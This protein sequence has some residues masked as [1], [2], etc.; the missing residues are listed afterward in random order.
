MSARPFNVRFAGLL[1]VLL[2]STALA[3]PLYWDWPEGV[4]LTEV[5]L[6]GAAL[7]EAGHLIAGLGAGP[8]QPGGP[9]VFW[10]IE[11]DGRGGFYSGTGHGGEIHHTDA[12]G[13]ARLVAQ[14]EAAEVFSLLLL[15]G[16]DLLAGC[17]PEGE[18]LRIAPD[19]TVSELA[20]VP[21][22]YVW[23]MSAGPDG[24]IWLATGSPAALWVLDKGGKAAPAVELP[25]QNVLDLAW[26]GA[27]RLL[28]STQGPGL[29]YRLD[30]A[31]PDQPELLFAADQGEVRQFLRGPG[32][33][34][35]VLALEV[36]D[37]DE[38]NG[39]RARP[40][41]GNGGGNG[42]GGGNG[43][44]GMISLRDLQ[45]EVGPPRA[46]L[47][48]LGADGLV[49]PYWSGET[50][51]MIAAW[52]E[53]WGWVGGGVVG[54]DDG[55]STLHRL[56]PPAGMQSLA[57]WE[58]GDVMAILPDPARQRLIVCEAHPGG[59]TELSEQPEGP[60]VAVSRIV[61]AGRSVRWG[62]LRWQ[63]QGAGTAP[64]WSVRS[65]NRAEPDAD[66]SDWSDAWRGHDEPIPAPAGRY[67]Q[68]RVAFPKGEDARSWQVTGVSLS[69][70]RENLPPVIAAFDLE[71]VQEI[72]GGGLM[73]RGDNVTQTLQSGL[74]VEYGRQSS[75]DQRAD[76]A[77][78]AETRSVRTLSWR[79]DDPDGDRLAYDL[80]FRRVGETVWRPV[81]TATQETI[82]A[83]DTAGLAD[84]QYELRLG[85][86]DALDNPAAEALLTRRLLAP[87]A[88]DNTPPVVSRLALERTTRGVRVRFRAEDTAGVLATATVVLP[89]GS[90]ER[91]DP[92]DRI[93]DSAREDFD[94][95]V[96]WPREGAAAAAGPWSL[97]VEVS[98]LGGNRGFADAEVP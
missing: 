2:A 14:V 88:V 31:H 18:L 26:D 5:T 41:G 24:R 32:G 1:P 86:S 19:G 75:R 28:A 16:G 45:L 52:T 62:R 81:L 27:G 29:V 34:L 54:D 8:L 84:G 15:P 42:S 69:A 63:G 93:C 77:R 68:W 4:P 13:K 53:R 67:L 44:G 96:V 78:A 21:G 7:D 35:F 11:A 71:Q 6:D 57:G 50:D 22:G 82:G 40:G 3:G 58:G 64:S 17:G 60:R 23:A 46:A 61:D 91:L 66:W 85:A 98:D 48:R 76:P 70:W 59:L 12:E 65:G 55:R 51:L 94:R 25:A 79:A 80:E 89:D 9:E 72:F 73:P 20:Q 37:A 74:R 87:V 92:A 47:Y 30:P 36:G 38:D 56:T 33:D 90:R 97:R 39:G 95:E 10:C 43:H 83:W 49:T